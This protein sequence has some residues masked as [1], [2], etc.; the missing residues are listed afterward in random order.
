M[1]GETVLGHLKLMETVAPWHY[2]PFEQEEY[3]GDYADLFRIRDAD[4]RTKDWDDR[5][6]DVHRI[7]QLALRL[8]RREDGQRSGSFS[9]FVDGDRGRIRL[10]PEVR[11]DRSGPGQ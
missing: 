4:G 11:L 8:R 10:F 5:Q 7:R 3:F 6:A 2:G 1:I 9:L